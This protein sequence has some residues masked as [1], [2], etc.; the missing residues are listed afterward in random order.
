MQE[1]STSAAPRENPG[2]AE[3]VARERRVSPGSVSAVIALLEGGA[4]IP[5]IARY[6]KDSTGGLDE[7]VLREIAERSRYLAE[8]A[9]RRLAVREAIAE[10]GKLTPELARAIADAKTKTEL[11]ELYAPFKSKRRTRGEIARELGL[12]P[13]ADLIWTRRGSG[14]VR[15]A[16]RAFVEKNPELESLE[17][18]ID[19]AV[20][21]CGERVA[22]DP[23]A[24]RIVLEALRRGVVRVKKSSKHKALKTKFDDY[25]D[26]AEPI[27]KVA[28]HRYLAICRGEREGILKPSFELDQERVLEEL[29]QTFAVRGTDAWTELLRRAIG[30]AFSRLLLGSARSSVRSELLDRAERDAVGIFAQNLESSCW[31]RR[32][33]QTGCSASIPASAPAASARSSTRPASCSRTACSTWCRATEAE[34]RRGANAGQDPA[35]RHPIAAVAVGNGTHGRETESFVRDRC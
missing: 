2:V 31:L 7:V 1:S 20:D 22:E 26:Y 12:E 19:G 16:A 15:V 13:L 29:E 8:L 14:D 32:S 25:A 17:A 28:S 34:A 27:P 10:R 33:G 9:E 30:D 5:F 4:T 24:R 23:R 21:I 35:S 18:A 11:E 6:R 3:L